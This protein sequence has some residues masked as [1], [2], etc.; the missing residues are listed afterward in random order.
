MLNKKNIIILIIFIV[1][2]LIFAG[3]FY[4][5]SLI[6]ITQN[7][8][9][10]AVAV[11]H[12]YWIGSANPKVTIIEFGDFSCPYCKDSF[13]KVRE[14]G[15]K[16]KDDIKIIYKDYPIISE[17]SLDLAMAGRCAGEQDMF[18]PMH[19]KL[20]LNQG[21]STKQELIELANQIGLDKVKFIICLNSQK[22]LNEIEKDIEIGKKLEM[23]GTPAWIINGQKIQ[24]SIP[25]DMFTQLIESLIN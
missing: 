11:D 15:I 5:A 1:L 4:I 6:P 19:D 16:Y 2:V 10:T 17:H 25:H 14:M 22:Y 13:S 12:N 24:G 7:S 8:T 9:Y 23:K 18:W 3:I 21:V 20:F